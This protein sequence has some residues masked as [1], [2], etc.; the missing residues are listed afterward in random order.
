MRQLAIACLLIALLLLGNGC[1]P[2]ATPPPA[3]ASSLRVV[4][5][6]PFLQDIAQNVAGERVTVD[7]LMPSG[8]DPHSY[9]P[10]PQDVAK[11]ANAQVVIINGA[12]LETFLE[13]LLTTAGGQQ[14]L[15]DASAGLESRE[16]DE[17]EGEA[18]EHESDPHFWLD[19][20][21]VIAYVENIRDGL[22]EADPDGAAAYAANATAYIAQLQELDQWITSQVQQVP[23]E[24][25]LL[26]TNHESFGYYA[27]RYG[28][29]VIGTL[30]PSVSSLASPSAQQLAQLVDQIRA[31]GAPAIFLE[32]GT[33]PQ[34]AQQVAQEAGV[35]LVTGLYTH[36][37]GPDAPT[38]IGMIRYN[39]SKIVEALK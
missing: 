2:T 7:V 26:V 30:I 9:E 8:A 25:R 33:N 34:L 15:I 5:I 35:R 38:Y 3:G 27:D 14:R 12:G 24:R 16:V 18:H 37:P 10:A 31:T 39:T 21:L 13:R 23:P 1:R 6:E 19:P 17:H 22:S 4:A 32:S 20:N 36:T 29:R 11:I 28:F